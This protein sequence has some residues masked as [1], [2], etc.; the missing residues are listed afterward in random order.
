MYDCRIRKSPHWR[1]R[2]QCFVRGRMGT[3]HALGVGPRL[4][5]C[6]AHAPAQGTASMWLKPRQEAHAP[7]WTAP[8]HH[9]PTTRGVGDTARRGEAEG[10]NRRSPGPRGLG[11]LQR[12]LDG[13]TSR[14]RGAPRTPHG[15]PRHRTPAAAPAPGSR[16]DGTGCRAAPRRPPVPR[17]ML[18]PP[19]ATAV[20]RCTT[21]HG[22]TRL[23]RR[24][25]RAGCR[26]RPAPPAPR[27]SGQPIPAALAY[28][29]RANLDGARAPARA[30]H[31]ARRPSGGG[32]GPPGTGPPPSSEASG[33]GSGQGTCAQTVRQRGW[34]QARARVPPHRVRSMMSPDAHRSLPPGL[35]PGRSP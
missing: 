15:T 13:E 31:A 20:T 26:R 18:L 27:R 12:R 32:H 35:F 3:A 4:L 33:L 23:G 28:P 8:P 29:A 24:T 21:A 22:P 17:R 2:L 9:G 16:A 25:A 11:G 19:T 7:G 14:A 34:P 1:G 10:P 30:S 6:L 5:A